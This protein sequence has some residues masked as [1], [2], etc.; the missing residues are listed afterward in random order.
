M[1][2]S[3]GSGEDEDAL[4]RLDVRGLDQ[5]LP[6]REP[7]E[8]ERAR[9]D[10]VQSRPGSRASWRDGEVTYSAYAAASRGKRGIPKTRSPT[11][12][13]VTP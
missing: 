5:R 2:D 9:L 12:N 10:V 7:R 4:T 13:L 1:P 8:R 11:E 6:G 3:A